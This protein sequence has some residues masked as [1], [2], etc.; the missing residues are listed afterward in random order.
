MNIHFYK[1][2]LDDNLKK[3]YSKGFDY[4]KYKSKV[5][6]HSYS[7]RETYHIYKNKMYSNIELDLVDKL[8]SIQKQIK[9]SLKYKI[10]MVATI[11]N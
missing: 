7:T 3:F 11:G 1:K 9:I 5:D 6:K 10:C 8:L 4:P 2:Q